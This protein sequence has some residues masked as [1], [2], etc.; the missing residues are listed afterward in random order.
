MIDHTNRRVLEVLENRD[1]A[2]VRAYLEAGKSNGLFAYLEEFTTDMWDGYVEAVKEV[3]GATVRVTID[4]FHVMKN[5]QD[6]LTDAR[7]QIQRELTKEEAQALKGTRWLWVTNPENLTAEQR[8]E[9]EQLKQRFPRLK[10]LVEHRETLQQV[11]EDRTIADAPTGAARLR[12]WIDQARQAG[13]KGL[14]KF[15]RTLENWLDKIANYFIN[16]ASNGRTEGFNHGLRSILWRA[17]GMKN[18]ANFRLR[19]LDRFGQPKNA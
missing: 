2:S 8:T 5:F 19:V 13:L 6:H 18:F 3:F 1:K 16:R 7:R 10:A 15:C 14:D 17:F 4:R 9:L 12:A 11:F